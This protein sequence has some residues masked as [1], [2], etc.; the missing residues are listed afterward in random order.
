MSRGGF[1][2]SMFLCA[3]VI[4]RLSVMVFG[5]TF[6]IDENVVSA[7]VSNWLDDTMFSNNSMLFLPELDDCKSCGIRTQICSI[8]Y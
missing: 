7:R 4:G 5:L 6:A 2:V 1:L 3:N 8:S